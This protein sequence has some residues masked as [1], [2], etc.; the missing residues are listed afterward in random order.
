MTPPRLARALLLR[1]VAPDT[2]GRS[3]VVDFDEEFVERALRDGA[4]RARRW[5]WRQAV[6]MWWWSAWA[7]PPASY[8]QPRG[9]MLFDV[10]GDL[11]HGVRVITKTPAQ[12]LLIVGTLAV[13]IGASTIGFAFA[14]TAFIRGL[15]V[16]DPARTVIIYGLDAREPDRR[17]GVY[18]SDVLDLRQRSRTVNDLSTWEQGRATLRRPG[19]D[20]TRVTVSRVTGDL[21]RVWGTKAQHG[22][23]LT[24]SDSVPSA[25]VAA[26]MSDRF[27]REAFGG[28][29]AAVGTSLFVDGTAVE[30]VGILSRDIEI[31]TFANI[32][33]WI[34][35]QPALA[36]GRDTRPVMVTGRLASDATVD[37]AAAEFRVFADRLAAEHP[38]TNR[39]RHLLV[40]DARRAVGGPNFAL[41]L[42]LLLGAAALVV[43][44]ASVNVAGVLLARA[45]VRQREF[46]LRIALGARN[47]RLFRQ[48]TVEGLL[49]AAAGALGGVAVAE[50]GLRVI[51]S[52]DAEPIFQ[53]IFIDGHEILFIALLSLLA[54]LFFSL[55]PALAAIRPDV[56]GVLKSTS[57]RTAGA[58]STRAR[59]AL[60]VAQLALAIALTVVGGLVARTAAAITL[61]PTGFDTA[62]LLSFTLALPEHSDDAA[63]RRQVLRAI[64]DL[65]AEDGLVIGALDTLP[66]ASFEASALVQPDGL[67]AEDRTQAASAHVIRVFPSTLTTLGV[68]LL[69]GR[70]FVS[71]D[72]DDDRRVAL[73]SLAAAERFF[74]G[75][76]S[77]IGRRLVVVEEG[78]STGYQVIGVTGNVRDTDP[79]TGPRARV[80]LPLTNPRTVSLIARTNGDL[81]TAAFNI[82]RVARE[83]VPAVPVE[84]LEP[85]DRGI[86]R[87]TG[88]DRVAMG[89]L[90]GFVVV[91]LVF[92]ATGLYGTVAVATNLR[93]AE[94]ATRVALGAT[95]ANIVRLVV[96]H[97]GRLVIFSL[98]PGIA[99]GLL[100]AGV[101]RGLL[102]GVTPL[103]PA[104]MAVVVAVVAV[105]AFAASAGPALR[106][107]R[108]TVLEAIRSE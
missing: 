41:V 53:Q 60:V 93:R 88:G 99:A 23:T 33:L 71:A 55:A 67:V 2:A 54:P 25:P 91:S 90:L 107:S 82:R 78:A 46:A 37:Q 62:N 19:L 51:R 77:A 14:D 84:T 61:A 20:P 10:I 44:I 87:I 47:A 65:L 3:I 45:V 63:E 83:L 52:V 92:A 80:W 97:T 29:P 16:A 58:H 64:A 104:N 21:F 96:L 106:A 17:G 32:A 101:I 11:R 31:G 48:V 75:A 81:A 70:S 24:A 50:T 43:V 76:A 13:G 49:L 74:D 95:G 68:P 73:I 39:G 34:A 5:Y 66:A 42:S 8:H 22:R 79:E 103:D 85:Y 6:S 1:A 28:D 86:A 94:F 7:H 40:L 36:G 105:I 69:H 59:D 89:M 9:D 27:W 35:D 98:L 56:A 38:E 15:P 4:R 102:W 30:V 12:S 26:V 72:A 57:G 108:V 18:L 100:I